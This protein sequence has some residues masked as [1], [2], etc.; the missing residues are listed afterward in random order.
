[1]LVNPVHTHIG[2]AHECGKPL[3]FKMLQLASSYRNYQVGLFLFPPTPVNLM[4][5]CAIIYNISLYQMWYDAQRFYLCLHHMW[6]VLTLLF[7]PT[8]TM[9]WFTTLLSEPTTNVR[10]AQNFCL[11]RYE[12]WYDLQ[13]FY[14]SLHQMCAGQQKVSM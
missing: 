6:Y 12:M 14:L 5:K 11:P 7:I 10:G 2:K 1:M 3:D 8:L 4:V 13:H 9:V